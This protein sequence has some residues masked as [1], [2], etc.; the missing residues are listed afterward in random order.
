MGYRDYGTTLKTLNHYQTSDSDKIE[1][2]DIDKPRQLF[3][4]KSNNIDYY[5]HPYQTISDPNKNYR[6]IYSSWFINEVYNSSNSFNH[7]RAFFILDKQENLSCK[8]DPYPSISDN[9]NA[10]CLICSNLTRYKIKSGWIR[11]GYEHLL[12]EDLPTNFNGF[13]F[14]SN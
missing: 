7:G 4:I 8:S 14:G 12:N 10:E 11:E 6:R 1:F 2:F 3:G 9:L 13:I 5:I